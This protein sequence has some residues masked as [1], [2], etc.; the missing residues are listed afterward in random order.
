MKL[1]QTAL[2]IFKYT[3]APFFLFKYIILYL[4]KTIT[5]SLSSA[6]PSSLLV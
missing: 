1:Q 5:V 3:T 4:F 6:N 2:R